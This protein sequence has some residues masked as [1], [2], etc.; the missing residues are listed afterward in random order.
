MKGS[1][2]SSVPLASLMSAYHWPA[3]FLPILLRAQVRQCGLLPTLIWNSKATLSSL[4]QVIVTS[5]SISLFAS[6][7][8]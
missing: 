8:A 1:D 4:R 3:S 6:I 2:T 7:H 5:V